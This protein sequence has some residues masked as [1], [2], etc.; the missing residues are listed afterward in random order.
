[1]V[2]PRCTLLHSA[3]V[4]VCQQC[5]YPFQS[6]AQHVGVEMVAHA[7]VKVGLAAGAGLVGI[8]ALS[9]L[10]PTSAPLLLSIGSYLGIAAIANSWLAVSQGNEGDW[11]GGTRGTIFSAALLYSLVAELARLNGVHE[12][13][14]SLPVG[15]R[16]QLNVPSPVVTELLACVL[17]IMDP[18]LAAPI[19]RWLGDGVERTA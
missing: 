2:C 19:V 7:Q 9:A 3:P 6:L 10:T 18:L 14:W 17:S 5:G 8:L 13:V 15:G 11:L 1:M 12:I 4:T 16:F